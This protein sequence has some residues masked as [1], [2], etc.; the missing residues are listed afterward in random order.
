M[1]RTSQARNTFRRWISTTANVGQTL[2]FIGCAGLM[3]AVIF[4]VTTVQAADDIQ[5]QVFRLGPHAFYVP[6]AWIGRQVFDVPTDRR[7]IDSPRP[8]PIASSELNISP[9]W[10]RLAQWGPFA[11]RELPD[12]IRIYFGTGPRIDPELDENR[13]WLDRANSMEADPS[14]FVRIATGFT[15]PG[16]RPQWE[17]FIYKGYVNEFGWPLVVMSVNGILDESV[18]EMKVRSDIIVSYHADRSRFER[19]KWWDLYRR[20]LAFLDFLEMPK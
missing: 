2:R 6:K 5:V 20:V 10:A 13:R 15:K 11:I 8:A 16:Q 14:G 12:L 3:L 4:L 9:K 1:T 19:S 7:S 18:V 17:R